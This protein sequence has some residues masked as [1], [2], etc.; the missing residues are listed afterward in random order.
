VT[1]PCKD[2]RGPLRVASSP[3]KPLG[4]ERDLFP[5]LGLA[6]PFSCLSHLIACVGLLVV[7]RLLWGIEFSS[8]RRRLGALCYPILGGF[9]LACSATYHALWSEPARQL[10]WHIDHATIWIAL[11]GT[12]TALMSVFCRWRPRYLLLIWTAAIVGAAMEMASLTTLA[13]WISPLL[14]VGMGWLGLPVLVEAGR[15][16]GVRGPP[17]WLLL[18][19]IVASVGG[20]MDSTDQ[21]VLLPHVIEAHELMH[22]CILIAAWLFAAATYVGARQRAWERTTEPLRSL[23]TA[24]ARA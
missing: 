8:R 7:A 13:P 15:R 10:F 24:P 1:L 11:A 3:T 5:Y 22:V 4:V 6:N 2:P 21:P 9:Q 17:S 20:V 23:L 19:G 18:A 12:A 14:Y 16:H